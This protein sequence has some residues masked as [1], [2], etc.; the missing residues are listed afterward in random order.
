MNTCLI[1]LVLFT[2]VFELDPVELVKGK[3]IEGKQDLFVERDPHRYVFANETNRAEFLR[4]PELYEVQLGG[5]CARMGPLS[6]LCRDDIFAVHEGRIYLFASEACRKTFLEAPEK[7]LNPDEKAPVADEASLRKGRELLE[8]TV[9]A[10][11]GAE[12]LDQ[13]RSYEE[14]T[15]KEET[16]KGEKIHTRNSLFFAYPNGVRLDS[17]WGKS[18]FTNVMHGEQGWNETKDSISALHSEEKRALEKEYYWRNLLAILRGRNLSGFQVNYSGPRELE[19]DGKKMSLET[20]TIFYKGVTNT[21]GI[22]TDTGRI[23]THS[24]RGRG[25][26]K[27]LFGSMEKVFTE[28]LDFDGLT[29]PVSWRIFFEGKEMENSPYTPPILKMN[30]PEHAALFTKPAKN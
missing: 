8:K 10:M 5:A 11:G 7:L 22:E 25:G 26:P 1:L 16:Y 19:L 6:G 13:V 15:I 4:S 3:Q 29:I 30:A 20:V 2:S 27:S 14:S 24:Y 18:R 23:R 9:Q 17:V 28:Y 21:L 12:R